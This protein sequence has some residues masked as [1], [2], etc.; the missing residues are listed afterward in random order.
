MK[1]RSGPRGSSGLRHRRE[2][3]VAVAGTRRVTLGGQIVRVGYGELGGEQFV[4]RD[5]CA[6]QLPVAKYCGD[7]GTAKIVGRG[8]HVCRDVVGGN[9][10]VVERRGHC[11][12][13]CMRRVEHGELDVVAAALGRDIFQKQFPEFRCNGVR[14][15]LDRVL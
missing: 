5:A 13:R 15:E 4:V 3:V 2:E 14:L 12:A 10:H 8:V 6:R 7:V 11:V 1:G 9:F